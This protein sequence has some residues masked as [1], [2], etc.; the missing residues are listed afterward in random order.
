MLQASDERHSIDA[1][2]L[3][4]GRSHRSR[5]HVLEHVDGSSLEIP[6][7]VIRGSTGGPT[8]Y[9]GAGI[10]GDEIN[11][12]D[13]VA[14]LARELDGDGLHGTVI[15]VPAQN[16]AALQVRHRY[17]VGH[18]LKSP[19]DQ[20]PADPWSSFPG[21]AEGNMASLIAHAL[22]TGLMR[23]ADYY[24]DI[25]TPTTGGRYAPFAFLPPPS[26]GA[27][28]AEAEAL[29]KAFGADFILA[30]ESGVYVQATNPHVVMARRGSVALG[31]EVGE[32]GQV[33]PAVTARALRGLRNVM[34]TIGMLDGEPE[35]FGRRMVIESMTIVRA[36]RGGLPQRRVELNDD[37]RQG[38]V[39]AT[40]MDLFGETVET[41]AAP[42]DG[43]IV[44][45]ATFPALSAGERVVQLGVA[46]GTG[47][48]EAPA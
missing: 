31:I 44:R 19:L 4:P 6:Y 33:D 46:R 48:V 24:I 7:W 30:T 1:L 26:T 47:T 17:P 16:P 25:H 42:H 27:M 3:T 10:H 36:H 2:T 23:H 15:L 9:L 22:L 8:L 14:R 28:A 37:V 45:I 40:V 38:D 29:A 5:L 20:S 35:T 13:V 21:D 32:G 41:I 18:L 43:P 39:V 11:G 34:R 12:V